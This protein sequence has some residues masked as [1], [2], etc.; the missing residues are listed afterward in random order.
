MCCNAFRQVAHPPHDQGH[1]EPTR[2]ATPTNGRDEASGNDAEAQFRLL[3]SSVE[4][5]AISMLDPRGRIV[6]WNAGAERIKGYA[7]EEVLTNLLSNAMKYAAG[8]AI[9]VSVAQDGKTAVLEVRDGGPGLPEADIDRIFG[10][11]ERATST[12]H[13]GL[14][15]GLYIT[16]QI[17]EAHHGTVTARN[18]DGGGASF[19]VR[20]PLAPPT[21]TGRRWEGQITCW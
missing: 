5:Y 10:R 3:V 15:L 16:R 18:L 14:G 19:V 20:L 17:V 4:D 8:T 11:F 2:R 13:G 6:T 1:R 12:N 7:A 9:E 21:P